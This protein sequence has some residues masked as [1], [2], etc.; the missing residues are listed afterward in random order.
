MKPRNLIRLLL[1]IV[2]N[3]STACSTGTS[4]T[5]SGSCVNTLYPVVK[6][7]SWTYATT[8][9]AAGNFSYTDIITDS[10][11]N[12][13]TLTSE[14]SN[15]TRTQEWSCTSEG[16][17]ALQP[18]N[19][20]AGISA[21]DLNAHFD[22]VDVRGVTVPASVTLGAHWQYLLVL[23]GQSNVNGKISESTNSISLKL[24]ISL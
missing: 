24:Q 3:A 21:I 17:L 7:A 4:K 12:G 23:K 9:G 16:L 14:F 11:D 8:G 10:R 20:S 13:F 2:L 1:L 22:T 19:D 5:A 6:G 15:M 18:G